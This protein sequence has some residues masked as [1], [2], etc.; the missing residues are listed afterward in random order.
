MAGHGG[1]PPL[2]R[3]LSE[4]LPEGCYFTII[5][6]STPPH[7]DSPIFARAPGQYEDL[8]YCEKHFLNVYAVHRMVFA[9]E[10]LIYTTKYLT[11][12]FVSKADS[13]GC[14]HLLNLPKDVPSPLRVV[15]S[16]FLRF[17]IDG[18]LRPDRKLVLSLF[19]RAQPTYLFP[20]SPENPHKHILDDKS[21]IKWWC[22]VI[23]PL[24]NE[25]GKE[26]GGVESDRELRGSAYLRVPG[27][28][29]HETRMFWPRVGAQRSSHDGVV[30]WTV[31]DPLKE[32]AHVADLPERCLIPRFPDDPKAR[33]LT[34]LDAELP[35]FERNKEPPIGMDGHPLTPEDGAGRWPAVRSLDD[36]WYMMS[37]RQEASAGKRVGFI[38]AVFEPREIRETDDAAEKGTTYT[39]SPTPPPTDA[40]P[41]R[42]SSEP[43]DPQQPIPDL[44]EQT[45]HYV[46]P[47]WS[48]GA[49]V[50]VPKDY[51]RFV[52][53]L[54]A[55]EHL[56]NEE[57]WADFANDEKSK[58]SSQRLLQ[59]LM[60]TVRG[61]P[62][63]IVKGTN[64][65]K[66]A[67]PAPVIERNPPTTLASGLLRKRRRPAEAG[68]D[69]VQ[70]EKT[71]SDHDSV[72]EGSSR[73]KT[74][75]PGGQG[76]PEE[77]IS[78]VLKQPNDED[79]PK[80]QLE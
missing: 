69:N 43:R 13:T 44:P 35:V 51:D 11:T 14:L 70:Q 79:N 56:S 32:L 30:R 37:F 67:P 55:A 25:R 80:A 65:T 61:V 5:H 16:T 72:P 19:A 60:N 46:W 20:C 9:I 50:M 12:V 53:L 75:K 15:C 66:I 73:K 71:A 39:R 34:D 77:P 22:K 68:T 6:L 36:F 8:T 33:Y 48:R 28:E 64:K 58:E 49:A 59:Y 4:A 47:C 3:L 42:G 26:Y 18:R 76:L 31:G 2:H 57:K 40:D 41:W 1:P 10:V 45:D 63:R 23:D 78:N 21:L 24:L 74:K 29:D 62:T 54:M 52:D 17:L 27:V 38:W 7:P